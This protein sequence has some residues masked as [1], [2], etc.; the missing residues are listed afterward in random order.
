MK[1]LYFILLGFGLF[2]FK[3]DKTK[4]FATVEEVDDFPIFV[5]SKPVA[6]YNIV[7]KALSFNDAFKLIADQKST[8]RKKTKMV[9]DFAL[10]R[11]KNGKIPQFDALIFELDRDKVHA[12]KF[13]SEVSL[14]A[15]IIDYNEEIPVFFFCEP[16]EKYSVVATMEADYSIKAANSGFLYD[17]INSMINRTLRKRE[18]KEV[19]N[20]DAIIISPNDL[21]EKLIVFE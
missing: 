15:E 4:H 10:N 6:D 7:G 13:K 14:K 16:N 12:V 5:F 3:S 21:S 9:V 1:K 8:I 19:K 20:F 11:V 17:K 2:A 18:N